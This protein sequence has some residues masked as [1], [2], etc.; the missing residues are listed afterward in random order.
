MTL[1][2][3]FHTNKMWLCDHM[4][5]LSL[6]WICLDPGHL[7]SIQTKADSNVDLLTTVTDLWR[8]TQLGE[9]GGGGRTADMTSCSTPVTIAVRPH[10]PLPAVRHVTVVLTSDVSMVS[11]TCTMMRR[12]I[13]ILR[14][15]TSLI[16]FW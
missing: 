3:I 4:A 12:V 14:R 5:D 10:S 2:T 15:K 11:A 8:S 1:Y 9:R 7:I 6:P 16:P 13:V